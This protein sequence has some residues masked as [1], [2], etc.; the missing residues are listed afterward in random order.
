[1]GNFVD[2]DGWTPE[3]S[4]HRDGEFS[5]PRAAVAELPHF[6]VALTYE[7]IGNGIAIAFRSVVVSQHFR[8][9][10]LRLGQKNLEYFPV[11]LV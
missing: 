4:M 8:Q 5:L 2:A 6:D 3:I 7:R 11:P 9:T 10:M 1:M